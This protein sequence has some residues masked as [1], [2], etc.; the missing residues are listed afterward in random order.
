MRARYHL[1]RPFVLAA[2]TLEPRKNLVRLMDAFA[3]LQP[4]LIE[5]HEL[6]LVGPRGWETSEIFDRAHALRTSVRVLGH[7][8]DEDLAALYHLCDV[9]GYPS[10]YEGFG[11]PVLEAMSAGAAVLTSNV[12]S[13][14]EVGGDAVAYVD[15]R[16][17]DSIR[18]GLEQLLISPHER[19]RLGKLARRRAPLFSWSRTAGEMLAGLTALGPETEVDPRRV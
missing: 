19:A 12:S 10:L 5:T 13:L 3:A 16:E 7:V 4:E 15:P 17:V 1:E 6:V 18:A 9:F 14:P 11:L 2:G 8:S